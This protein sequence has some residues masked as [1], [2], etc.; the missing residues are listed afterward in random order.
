[1]PILSRIIWSILDKPYLDVP[2]NGK[3]TRELQF[4]WHSSKESPIVGIKIQFQLGVTDLHIF[5][6]LWLKPQQRCVVSSRVY[7]RAETSTLNLYVEVTHHDHICRGDEGWITPCPTR[8]FLTG[9]KFSSDTCVLVLPG[10]L[11]AWIRWSW[12]SVNTVYDQEPQVHATIVWAASALFLRV[13]L[14][15]Q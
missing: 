14:T 7:A 10:E 8:I 5:E 6:S 15:H 9:S 13:H 4:W 3:G 12:H 11:F 1:M 2:L